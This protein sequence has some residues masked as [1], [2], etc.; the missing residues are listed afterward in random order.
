MYHLMI[1]DNISHTSVQ[2]HEEFEIGF[3]S[4]G[5]LQFQVR[6]MTHHLNIVLHVKVL[7]HDVPK[8]ITDGNK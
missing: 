4:V 8:K 2:H 5:F 3:Q 7:D 6:S 1:K